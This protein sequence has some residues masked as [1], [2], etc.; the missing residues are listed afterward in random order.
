MKPKHLTGE[1]YN[2]YLKRIGVDNQ[3]LMG[4]ERDTVW[5][6]LQQL[7]PL[8]SWSN[9]RTF[10]DEYNWQGNIYRVHHGLENEPVI[11]L[12]KE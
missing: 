3:K 2:S 12:I 7:E 11:E 8:K 9:Q 4:D 5:N 10:T 6:I 1:E